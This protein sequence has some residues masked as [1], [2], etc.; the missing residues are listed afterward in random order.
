AKGREKIRGSRGGK[1]EELSK[2]S[3]VCETAGSGGGGVF[4]PLIAVFSGVGP[5]F[6]SPAQCSSAAASRPGERRL[7]R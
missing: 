2:E 6:I 3:R 7:T 1:A 5:G 4:S